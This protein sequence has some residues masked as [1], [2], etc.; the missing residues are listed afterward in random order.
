MY[1]YFSIPRSEE[2]DSRNVGKK[3]DAVSNLEELKL[4]KVLVIVIVPYIETHA[5]EH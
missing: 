2:Q 4:A 1:C 5:L 3:L